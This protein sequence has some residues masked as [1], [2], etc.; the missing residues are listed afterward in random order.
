MLRCGLG[1][2]KATK[3]THLHRDAIT[4]R[5]ADKMQ[6][7]IFER[8]GYLSLNSLYFTN[9]NLNDKKCVFFS[10]ALP[11]FPRLLQQGSPLDPLQGV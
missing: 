4:F 10:L 8:E 3:A 2:K 9:Q 5:I 7:N 1:G 6:K 11:P